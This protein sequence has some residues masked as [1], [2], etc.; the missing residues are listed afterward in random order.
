MVLHGIARYCTKYWK[1][2][3]Y[4]IAKVLQYCIANSRIVS[5]T[6]RYCTILCNTNDDWC[7]ASNMNTY[8]MAKIILVILA[9][10][11]DQYNLRRQLFSTSFAND[12][13]NRQARQAVQ[14]LHSRMRKT[15][16]QNI[17]GICYEC[18]FQLLLPL[19][20]MMLNF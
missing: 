15:D 19:E 5:N 2:A 18:Y 8:W 10:V 12:K 6:N 11:L 14:Q 1:L 20:Q 17:V 3:R 4:D 7:L 9:T 16:G 13:E